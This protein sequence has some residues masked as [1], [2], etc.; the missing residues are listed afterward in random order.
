MV[1][2]ALLQA[3]RIKHKPAHYDFGA[4]YLRYHLPA[5]VVTR[6][7]DLYFIGNEEDLSEKYRQA[8]AWYDRTCEGIDFEKI[9][10]RLGQ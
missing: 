2:E 3:L 8:L 7:K 4:S 10:R 6:L 5:E 1:L 9:G